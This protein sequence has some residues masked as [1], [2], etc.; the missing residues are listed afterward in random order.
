MIE[1][2]LAT[3]LPLVTPLPDYLHAGGVYVF[4]PEALINLCMMRRS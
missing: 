3:H 1:L 4:S 2:S